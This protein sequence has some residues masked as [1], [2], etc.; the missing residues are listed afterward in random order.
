M[1]QYYHLNHFLYEK[2]EDLKV[3]NLQYYCQLQYN[4]LCV[5]YETGTEIS[6]GDFISYDPRTSRNKQL[7]VLRIPKDEEIQHQLLERTQL[8]VEY[9][10]E[11]INQISNAKAI[12]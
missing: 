11:K 2:A 8:A 4:M 1:L 5:E 7:K 10:K 9:F 6:F 12:I 3:D